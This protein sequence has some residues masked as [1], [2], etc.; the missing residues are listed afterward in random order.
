MERLF[1]QRRASLIGVL[2]GMLTVVGG[3]LSL[4]VQIVRGEPRDLGSV[5]QG[6]WG[7]F[8]DVISGRVT[9]FSGR[10]DYD[11]PNIISAWLIGLLLLAILVPLGTSLA[12]LLGKRKRSLLILSLVLASL[13]CLELL[14]MEWFMLTFSFFPPSEV[15]GIIGPGFWFILCG[16]LL[17][18]GS[19]VVEIVH[20]RSRA[21]RGA[22]PYP[23]PAR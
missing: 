12:A 1:F 23:F 17:S 16:F 4:G 7:F 15:E 13:G 10:I 5:W 11:A 19:S 20:F 22:S 9:L 3:F 21:A 8:T 18:I 6:S 14:L 2:A